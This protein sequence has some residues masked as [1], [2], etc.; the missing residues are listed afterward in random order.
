MATFE[1]M[2][3]RTHRM[4]HGVGEPMRNTIDMMSRLAETE[5]GDARTLEALR[6]L[7][8]AMIGMMAVFE[9]IEGTLKAEPGHPKFEECPM[10]D[11][12]ENAPERCTTGRGSTGDPG[13]PCRRQASR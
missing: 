1:E 13:M 3:D 4:P 8:E 10:L 2:K 12:G 9:A 11:M 5:A 6:G 7:T